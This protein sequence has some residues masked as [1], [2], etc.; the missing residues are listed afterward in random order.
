MKTNISIMQRM[1][2]LV[3]GLICAS[4][5]N[6]YD[7]KAEN[8][9]GVTIYYTI[10]NDEDVEVTYKNLV[11]GDYSGIVRIP[12]SVDKTNYVTKTFNVTRIGDFAFYDCIALNTIIL[13]ETITK[14]GNQSFRGCISISNLS[15]PSSL[16][17]IG[18]YAFNDCTNIKEIELPNGL[19]KIEHGA[20]SNCSS[21]V[22]V[23]IPS[24]VKFIGNDA[25]INCNLKTI[26]SYIETPFV[27]DNAFDGY[28][29]SP[30][31]IAT[32]YVPYGTKEVYQNTK[33]WYF[34]NIVEMEPVEERVS[35]M[36]NNN[37]QSFCCN[38]SLDFSG[39]GTPTAYIASGFSSGEVLLAK[40]DK[41][42]ANTGVILRGIAG[43]TYEVPFTETDFIYSNLLVGV[44]EDTTIRSGYVLDGDLFVDVSENHIINA[45][46]AY[47]NIPSTGGKNQLKIKFTDTDTITG[48]EDLETDLDNNSNWYTLQGIRLTHKPTQRGIYLHQGKKVM[49]K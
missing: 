12:S 39:A 30:N 20:F 45:G 1:L 3:V 2:L 9:D 7:F 35:I 10:I 13:P 23:S 46:E 25:F 24:S 40:V 8:E 41:V 26:K 17:E 42:P 6:A 48:V 19:V 28:S 43:K 29:Y 18:E 31:K 47:L 5:I 49:V 27:I 4:H 37:L 16:K 14:I 36:M 22:S 15:L 33:G 11:E 34:T 32:L 44:T 21:L 38:Q